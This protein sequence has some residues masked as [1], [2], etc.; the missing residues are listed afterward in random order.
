MGRAFILKSKD[1]VSDELNDI[2]KNNDKDIKE[3]DKNKKMFEM[4]K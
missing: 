1:Q 4:K 3:Y 2:I